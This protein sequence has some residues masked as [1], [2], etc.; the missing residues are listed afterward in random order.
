MHCAG[1]ARDALIRSLFT[2]RVVLALSVP[3]QL[4]AVVINVAQITGGVALGFVGEVSRAGM[5][6]L[7]A[8]RDRFGTHVIAKL[9]HCDEAVA[10]GAVPLLCI[11][12]STCSE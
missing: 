3:G 11:G 12:V 6:A 2:A 1:I 7:A 5:A 4:R 10:A 8:G 9:N